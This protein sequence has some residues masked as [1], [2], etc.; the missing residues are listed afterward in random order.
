M[1]IPP[2]YPTSSDNGVLNNGNSLAALAAVA[3]SSSPADTRNDP[4]ADVAANV[5]QAGPVDGAAVSVPAA[6]TTARTGLGDRKKTKKRPREGFLSGDGGDGEGSGAGRFS[7]PS[8]D[9]S[10]AAAA[11]LGE[12]LESSLEALLEVRE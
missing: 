8:V 2:C 11:K 3:A 4:A 5:R 6:K 7:E 10:A 9:P 1:A 12:E